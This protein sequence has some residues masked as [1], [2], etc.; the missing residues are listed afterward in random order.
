M[1]ASGYDGWMGGAKRTREQGE[2]TEDWKPVLRPCFFCFSGLDLCVCVRVCF[3]VPCPCSP[4][5][6]SLV[7]ITQ[8]QMA[9]E[10]HLAGHR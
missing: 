8:E 5:F 2:Q 3:V 7:S 1:L 6:C 4:A 10:R 9:R